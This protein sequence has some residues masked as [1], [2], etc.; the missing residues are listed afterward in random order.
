M[1]PAVA[2]EKLFENY[3]MRCRR[4]PLATQNLRCPERAALQVLPMAPARAW[5]PSIAQRSTPSWCCRSS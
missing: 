4:T 3:A 2:L 1:M 5:R